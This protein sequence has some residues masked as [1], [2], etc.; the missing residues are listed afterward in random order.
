M[1][2]PATGRSLHVD[3]PLSNVV[4]G[5]RPEGFIA[6]K[7]LP[8][9]PV[10]KQSDI[11]WKFIH[12]E[13]FRYEAN[14]SA[15]APGTEAKK[16]HMTVSSDTYY[17]KNYELG[18]DWPVEDEVNA[19]AA[20]RWAESQAEF[21]TDRL[22]MDYEMRIAALAVNTSN[23]QTVTTVATA[24]SNGVGARIF[25]DIQGQIELFRQNTGLSV[26]RLV[27]PQNVLSSIKV[28]DQLRNLAFGSTQAGIL[29][30]DKIASLFDLPAGSVL[31]PG[32]LV[33]TGGETETQ[34][35][36]A[37][38]FGNV[39]GNHFWLGR[40]NLAQGFINDTWGQAFRWTSP[41]FNQPFYVQRYP[42]DPKK[43]NYEIAVGYY[44]GEKIVSPDLMVRIASVV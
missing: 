29:T 26:N 42:F 2:A 37:P 5:R 41:L 39:W 8:I 18:G 30:A 4:I 6:D 25:D 7:L 28:N 38:A 40:V 24:W 21:I 19:D 35:G 11:Y 36:S 44:Q 32:A 3:V 1:P 23:V 34:N 20:L 12:K 14:L 31:V 13:W 17:A 43:K 33:N 10:G 27:I 22:L 15:R 9:V 16:V